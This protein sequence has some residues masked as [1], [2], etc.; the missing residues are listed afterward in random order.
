MPREDIPRTAPAIEVQ[1]VTKAFGPRLVLK[2]VDLVARPGDFITIFGPNGAG[3][4]TLIKILA[5]LSWASHGLVRIAGL[6]IRKSGAEARKLIGLVSH[7]MMLY[8]D[9]TAYEN[10]LFYGNMYGASALEKRIQALLDQVGLAPN[11]H[12]R[13]G[14]F[15]HGMRKRL[16]IARAFVH[17][18]PF[19][20]LDEPETGLDQQGSTMLVDTLKS[21]GM[22]SRTIIMTTHSLERGPGLGTHVAIL[23]RGKIVY[24]EPT[25][26]VDLS[27][28]PETYRSYV[29]T[30]A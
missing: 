22:E 18:P 6:D 7:D 24:L 5:T 25:R 14:T 1:G 4:T 2:G 12:Q 10:L 15:S 9:L 27:C 23:C 3:K 19:L 29:E 30:A 11:A 16:S 17:D 20:L 26:Q 8:E 13:V 28:F 21:L